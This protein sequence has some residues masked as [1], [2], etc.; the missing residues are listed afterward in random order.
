VG[1]TDNENLSSVTIS[2]LAGAFALQDY[3][4]PDEAR[5]L[6]QAL[7]DC[8]DEITGGAA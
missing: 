8:A 3:L 6:G 1:P 5:R 7:I 2:V 4:T